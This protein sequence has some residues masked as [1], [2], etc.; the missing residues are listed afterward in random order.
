MPETIVLLL[1]VATCGLVLI[2]FWGIDLLRSR[3]RGGAETGRDG[4]R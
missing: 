1:S 2:A 3:P 4:R